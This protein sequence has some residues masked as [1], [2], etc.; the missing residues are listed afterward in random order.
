[1]DFF[2]M[3]FKSYE[4]D[5]DVEELLIKMTNNSRWLINI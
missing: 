5:D 1:M 3:C 4:S 2:R